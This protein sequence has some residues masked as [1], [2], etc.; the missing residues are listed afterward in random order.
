MRNVFGPGR[1]VST[2][3]S[4]TLV[5]ESTNKLRRLGANKHNVCREGRLQRNAWFLS[6][7]AFIFFFMLVFVPFKGSDSVSAIPKSVG[8]LFRQT[9]VCCLMVPIWSLRLHAGHTKMIGGG[10]KVTLRINPLIHLNHSNHSNNPNHLNQ[11]NNLINLKH[12]NRL[13]KDVG[14]TEQRKVFRLR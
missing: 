2:F 1:P 7:R 11:L 6:F 4:F 3:T 9:G 14:E 12:L 10:L 5:K 8:T 13:T